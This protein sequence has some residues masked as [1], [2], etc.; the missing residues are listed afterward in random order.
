M[1]NTFS[2]SSR[3]FIFDYYLMQPMPMCEFRVNQI[4]A[5]NPRLL[6]RLIRY[7]TYPFIGKYTNQEIIFVN[8]RN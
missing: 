5:K 8:G 1:R 4:L 6:Y 7:S 3:D 2:S